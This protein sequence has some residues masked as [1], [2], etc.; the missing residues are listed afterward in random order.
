MSIENNMEYR[1]TKTQIAFDIADVE[2]GFLHPIKRYCLFN[3]GGIVYGGA[4]DFLNSFLT[5]EEAE[6]YCR[7][8]NIRGHI[9][10]FFCNMEIVSEFG[11]WRQ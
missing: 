10:D 8:N 2:T 4:N 9:A 7:K 1:M 6:D 11:E 3:S 5:I